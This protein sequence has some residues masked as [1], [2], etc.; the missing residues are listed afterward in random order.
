VRRHAVRPG[1][2]A[3]PGP[4]VHPLGPGLLDQRGQPPDPNVGSLDWQA[5]SAAATFGLLGFRPF[6]KRS[7]LGDGA[8]VGGAVGL[9]V[10]MVSPWEAMQLRKA[11]N[12]AEKRPPPPNPPFGRSDAHACLAFRIAGL[13][14]PNPPL[15][16]AVGRAVGRTVG[17]LAPCWRRHVR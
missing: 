11:W 10:G 8:G 9:V 16:N 4:A 13:G 12:A 15:G 2:I 17:M 6:R 1:L 3:Q 14:A 7:A 5:L